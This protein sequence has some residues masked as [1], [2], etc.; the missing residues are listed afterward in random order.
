M[1][2]QRDFKSTICNLPMEKNNNAEGKLY[3]KRRKEGKKK[4]QGATNRKGIIANQKKEKK[5]KKKLGFIPR[6]RGFR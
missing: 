2:E 6:V 1:K 4:L 3:K 5:E